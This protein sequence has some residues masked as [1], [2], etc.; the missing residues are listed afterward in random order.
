MIFDTNNS[1]KSLGKWE[2][3]RQNIVWKGS[4]KWTRS[5]IKDKSLSPLMSNG[6][7]QNVCRER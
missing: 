2:S 5:A 7:L 1:F 6:E 3:I 4:N